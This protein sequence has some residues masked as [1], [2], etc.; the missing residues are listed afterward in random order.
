MLTGQSAIRRTKIGTV[1]P[2]VRDE[3]AP[4]RVYPDFEIDS[5]GMAGSVATTFIPV[6]PF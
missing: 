5:T 1:P 2:G 6:T 3:T 4:F